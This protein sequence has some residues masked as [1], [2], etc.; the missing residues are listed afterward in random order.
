MQKNTFNELGVNSNIVRA[1]SEFGITEPTD[2]QEKAIPLI[3]S[4]KDII[5]K[6]KTGSGKTAAFGIPLIN[7]VVPKKGVQ[8]LILAP[9]RELA[10]QI[11]RELGKFGK[12]SKLGIATVYGGVSLRPQI[13]D[14]A[15]SEIVVSTPGRLLDHLQQRNI[16]LSKLTHFVLDEADRLVD[17][18]FIRD[19]ERIL[20]YT[21]KRKQMILFGATISQE[22]ARIKQRHMNNPVVAESEVHVAEEYLEQYYYNVQKQ[23]KF[24]LLVHLLDKEDTDQAIVFCSNRHTV[25]KVS[26][27]LRK[28]GVKIGMIHGRLAQNKRLRIIGQFNNGRT[29]LL[30]A[31]PVV[32]RGIDIKSVSHIFNYDLSDDPQ[33]YIHRVGRTARGGSTGKAITLLSNQDHDIFRQ[34]LNNY[35]INIKELTSDKFPKLKFDVGGDSRKRSPRPGRSWGNRG[36]HNRSNSRSRR[37]NDSKP[38]EGRSRGPRRFGNNGPRRFGNNGSRSND[39]KP[40]EGRSRGPRRFGNNK[41]KPSRNKNPKS[42]RVG[43]TMPNPRSR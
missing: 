1:L 7:K 42:S 36:S 24:S 33:E 38:S 27:N 22:I 23:E 25:E 13:K 43:S 4:G 17:M 28:Q 26:K 29:E 37:S 39:S 40:S 34:I 32:A 31:S 16:D 3:N 14:I 30:V 18:G 2:I 35:D 41:S 19:I 20:S 9:T 12:Y 5:G 15:R 11:S 21:P 8:A 10:V 6:S